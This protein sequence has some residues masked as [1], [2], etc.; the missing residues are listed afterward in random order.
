MGYE[1]YSIYFS[2]PYNMLSVCFECLYLLCFIICPMGIVSIAGEYLICNTVCCFCVVVFVAEKIFHISSCNSM[3]WSGSLC[4]QIWSVLFVNHRLCLYRYLWILRICILPLFSCIYLWIN[5]SVG[6]SHLRTGLMEW[7]CSQWV[8]F[9]PLSQSVRQSVSDLLAHPFL[10]RKRSASYSNIRI[11][12]CSPCWC[13]NLSQDP[14]HY[15]IIWYNTHKLP[16][17]NRN[18][19]SRN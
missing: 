5:L 6:S 3:M 4:I 19:Y 15:I 9:K 10:G 16:V 11:C 18:I 12:T 2:I 13:T 7:F 8:M 14:R 1:L 17:W